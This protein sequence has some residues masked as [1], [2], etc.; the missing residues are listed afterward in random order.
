MHASLC[1]ARAV[2]SARL[3]ATP[4]APAFV[5]HTPRANISRRR[6]A[7][8]TRSAATEDGDAAPAVPARR[9]DDAVIASKPVATTSKNGNTSKALLN[10]VRQALV[11]QGAS[12]AA[13]LRATQRFVEAFEAGAETDVL[14]AKALG[15]DSM[16]DVPEAQKIYAEK[17]AEKLESNAKTLRGEILAATKL[18][19]G[20]V[21]AYSRGL[22]IDAV[23]YFDAAAEETSETSLLGGKIQIYK[24]IA[25]D[26]CGR[27]EQALEIYKYLVAVHPERS[28]KKQ[29]EEL[30]FILEAPKM[31]I[32]ANERVEVPLLKNPDAYVPYSD[33]WSSSAKSK[34]GASG[35]RR[36][37]S[38][39]AEYGGE[40]PEPYD[41]TT[42][43]KYQIIAGCVIA[44]GLAW[45]STTLR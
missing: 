22:Y 9:A 39:E 8:S 19:D 5:A 21:Y 41:Y 14:V 11:P 33:K 31:E 15:Y 16:K 10:E 1:G 20:G 17:I 29:A 30:K 6:C 34:S 38:L 40:A 23:K 42:K 43:Y 18:Y 28:V 25:L 24:A 13:V 35:K 7:R 26:A 36:E 37:K 3:I 32:A 12:A 45:Y 4:R 2:M 44:I 27:G